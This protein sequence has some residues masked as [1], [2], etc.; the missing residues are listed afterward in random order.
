VS[1]L[2]LFNQ[3]SSGGS[4]TLN[5]DGA[6]YS[7][8]GNN[9]NLTYTPLGSYVL[10][11]DG[12]TYTYSGNNANTNYNR[13]F[14]CDGSTY[15]Y[16]GNDA[17]L[18]YGTVGS[19]TITADGGTYSYSGNNSNLLF[20]RVIPADGGIFSYSGNNATLTYSGASTTCPTAQE[21]AQEVWNYILEGSVSAGQMLR[22]VT[23]TQLA[24]VDINETTGQ[25]TIYKLD[26]TTVF[27]QA[28][29]SPTGDRNAPTV[30]WN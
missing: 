27:A 30:D 25:V 13:V 1:L 26:G 16:S 10:S 8:T 11:A 6:V 3:G 20:N 21:I 22:G 12:S 29:T 5:A 17:N 14:T 4:Y 19:Y 9:A 23:R 24:R 28:S 18:V 15:S 2:L 7:Y